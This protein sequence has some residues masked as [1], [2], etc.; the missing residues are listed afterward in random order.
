M[1]EGRVSDRL[2]F[3]QGFQRVHLSQPF[4]LTGVW[5]EGYYHTIANTGRCHFRFCLNGL[6]HKLMAKDV[7]MKCTG[8]YPDK[9]AGPEPQIALYVTRITIS[10]GVYIPG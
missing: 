9:Y 4:N 7:T 6:C 1:R 10:Y 3:S 5:E 8:V 2:D